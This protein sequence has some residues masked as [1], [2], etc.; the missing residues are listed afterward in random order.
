MVGKAVSKADLTPMK[1]VCFVTTSPLIVNFF[2]VPHLLHLSQRYEVTLAVNVEEGAPLLP[3]PGVEVVSL[4]IRRRSSPLAD[5]QALA[6]L[7]SL[8]SSRRFHLVH[9][10]S[11]KA[12]LLTMVAG[13]ICGVPRRIHTFTGQVWATM[14]GPRRFLVKAADR[15][16]AK[17]ATHILTDSRS[18]C[19]FLVAQR[20]V[21]RERCRVLGEGSVTGVDTHRFQ[22]NPDTRAAVRAELNIPKE[23]VVVLFL[24]RLKR[25]KGVLELSRAFASLAS[26]Q[27]LA[28]L[29]LVG[30]DEDALMPRITEQC[31]QHRDHVHA[32]GYTFAPERYVA[33]SDILALPSH[34]EGFG[35]VIIEA[36]AAGVPAVASRIYGIT[37][38][39]A[40]GETGLLHKPGDWKDLAKQLNR[41][42]ADSDLRKQLGSR[43]QE[44]ALREFRQEHLVQLLAEFYNEILA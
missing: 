1:R 17:C 31:S 15:C 19:E 24:G 43:A 35:S 6:R 32:L 27:D 10:F 3:L 29:L 41:L 23:A 44:R 21:A 30:P 42:L 26:K 11:P 5:F 38:A 8:F 7:I 28:H 39:V 37:D 40:D 4:P 36:A 14:R 34:R 33:A 13:R 16:T 12:G 22:G 20:V 2:L 25:D 18:Q 9:S